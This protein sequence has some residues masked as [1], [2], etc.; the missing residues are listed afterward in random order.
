MTMMVSGCEVDTK[1]VVTGGNPPAIKFKGTGS[2][3]QFFVMGPYTLEQL[4]QEYKVAGGK[5]VLTPEE[6]RELERIRGDKDD[7]MWQLAP[8]RDYRVA[9]LSITYGL[10][11]DGFKQVYPADGTP[12]EPLMEGKIYNILTPSASANFKPVMF[13]IEN[14]KAVEVPPNKITDK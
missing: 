11:P 14:G 6:T 5:N 4:R 7:S 1:P 2:L 3:E 10:V 9:G 13:T 12:P 8:S